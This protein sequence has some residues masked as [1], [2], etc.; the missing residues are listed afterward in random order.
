MVGMLGLLLVGCQTNKASLLPE[1][2]YY[3]SPRGDDANPGNAQA[4]FRTIGHALQKALPG[5]TVWVEDGIYEEIIS[6]PRSGKPEAPIVLKSVTPEGAVIEG[7]NLNPANWEGLINI[8]CRNWIVVDGFLVRNSRQRGIWVMGEKAAS[9]H[10][11]LRNCRTLNTVLSGFAVEFSSDVK[12]ENCQASFAGEG[13]AGFYFY[14]NQDVVVQGC[15]ADHN[16]GGGGGLAQGFVFLEGANY[17]VKDCIARSNARDGF[18]TGGENE[19]TENIRFESCYSLENGEDG[20][21]L[22][23]YASQV[24][25]VRCVSYRNAGNDFNIYEGASRVE[26]FNCTMVGSEHYFWIDGSDNPNRP[27]SDVQVRNCIG[28]GAQNRGIITVGPISNVT[29]DYNCWTGNYSGYGE[30]CL[31]NMGENEIAL[32]YS[33]IGVNGNWFRLLSQGEHSFSKDPGFV[34]VANANFRLRSDSPCIDAGVD[35]GLPYNG[36]APDLGAF[37]Y[38]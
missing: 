29:F 9:R 25:Y 26:V 24:R 33:D 35:V 38:P 34:D 5:D 10:V 36:K 19:G 8:I 6:F 20:F 28:Y 1:K 37:E 11:V 30:F 7:G 12:L 31:W 22:N 16:G 14:R 3:V 2:Y 18:D 17:L 27:V 21:G 4:P 13:Y 23:S 15:I 32:G